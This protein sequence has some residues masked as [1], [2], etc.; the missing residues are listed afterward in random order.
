MRPLYGSSGR[1]AELLA[2]LNSA[3]RH[4]RTPAGGPIAGISAALLLTASAGFNSLSVS[5]FAEVPSTAGVLA[6]VLIAIRARSGWRAW[7]GCGLILG[8]SVMI[9]YQTLAF[10][11]AFGLWLL[12]RHRARGVVGFGGGR[13]LAA[14]IQ[15]GLDQLAY[16]SPFHSLIESAKYNVTTDEAS[17]FYGS[18]P[19]TWYILSIGDWLGYVVLALAA[20]GV[21]RA[22]RERSSATWSG[23]S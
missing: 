23:F 19:A 7:L 4:D 15:A 14:L 9:R 2:S 22:L 21:V 20:L 16:G 3:D 18:E 8:M 1:A 12:I 5:T 13:H 11:P 10:V 6:A 17:Q